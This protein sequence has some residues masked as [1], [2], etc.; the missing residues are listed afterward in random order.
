VTVSVRDGMVTLEGPL[1]QGGDL[2]LAIRLT[3]RVDGVVGVVNR[4]TFPGASGPVGPR[5]GPTGPAGE[6][7]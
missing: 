4:L 1:E 7:R 5:Q 6:P 2:P 3:Y